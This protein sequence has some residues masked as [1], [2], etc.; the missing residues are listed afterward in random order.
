MKKV[1]IIENEQ[2]LNFSVGEVRTQNISCEGVTDEG[3]DIGFLIQ[4]LEKEDLLP[5]NN[6]VISMSITEAKTLAKV[7][8]DICNQATC[9]LKSMK[10]DTFE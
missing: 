8:K 7:L 9:H 5:D 6:L 1:F 10:N 3:S 2:G 4:H